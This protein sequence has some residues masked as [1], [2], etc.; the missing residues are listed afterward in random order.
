MS[1]YLLA[2]IVM[3][4]GIGFDVV[5]ATLSRLRHISSDNSWLWVKRISFTHVLFPMIGYYFFVGLF[6][7]Y[8]FLRILLGIIAFSLVVIFLFDIVKGWLSQDSQDSDES[9]FAWAVVLSVSWDALFSGPAKSAQAIGWSSRQVLVSFIIS[10][11]VVTSM[12]IIA[13]IIAKAIR[14]AITDILGTEV[15]RLSILHLAM[16]YF[17]FVILS[18][19]GVL[20]LIR[21]TLASGLSFIAIAAIS[22]A[23]G[24]VLFFLLRK[25]LLHNTQLRV[26]LT[27]AGCKADK[28]DV[29]IENTEHPL[30]RSARNVGRP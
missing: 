20:A 18:Y 4:L 25:S 24:A 19:F 28:A 22:V 10:G 14:R 7:S 9:P 2:C 6:R 12:A 11:A 26:G 5:L 8:P 29:D 21:Y 1:I 17:E 13:V 16:M 30:H 27:I 15:Y 3:G 23:F